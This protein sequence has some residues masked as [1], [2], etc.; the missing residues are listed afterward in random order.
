MRRMFSLSV[1]PITALTL[2]LTACG[3]TTDSGSLTE[4][5]G[6]IFND[7]T[8][9]QLCG[10][11]AESFPPQCGDPIIRLGDLRLDDVVALQSEGATS[12][13]D[14]EAG[15]AGDQSEGVLTNVVLTDPIIADSA[16]GFTLRIADLG[17]T[18]GAPIVLPI[19]LRNATD[20]DATLTFTSGQR[21]EL[22]LSQDGDEIYRWSATASFIQSVEEVTIAAGEVF[23]STLITTPVDLPPGTFTAQA[24][25]TAEEA[26]DLV[27]EWTIEVR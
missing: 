21:V 1:A 24:W 13:T 18:S 16:S 2:I 3:T 6:I 20:A 23:G 9:S 15:V 19:D 10:S 7:S 27:V 11:L 5:S 8:G 22:T 14:Y 26:S 25:I 17:I 12:W 4:Y